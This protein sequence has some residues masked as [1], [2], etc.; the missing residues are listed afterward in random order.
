MLDKDTPVFRTD[1]DGVVHL[2][3][4]GESLWGETEN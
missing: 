4:N 1:E 3:T 2:W